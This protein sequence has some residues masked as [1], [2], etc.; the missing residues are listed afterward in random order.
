MVQNLRHRQP[1]P[2]RGDGGGKFPVLSSLVGGDA[3]WLPT[4]RYDPGQ[5]T[6]VQILPPRSG[7]TGGVES[8]PRHLPHVRPALASLTINRSAYS[9]R[10]W[11]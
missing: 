7:L 2:V 5:V 6:G 3:G 10:S 1:W 8:A 9:S 4:Q 11:P